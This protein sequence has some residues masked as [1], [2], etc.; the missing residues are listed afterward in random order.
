MGADVTVNVEEDDAISVVEEVTG[1]QMADVVLEVTSS[2]TMQ[3]LELAL[4]VVGFGGM[5]IV[6]GVE[7]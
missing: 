5:V 1:G 7:K 4:R 3:P 2:R 6:A